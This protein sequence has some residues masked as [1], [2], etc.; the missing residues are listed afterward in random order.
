MPPSPHVV[1]VMSELHTASS[2]PL[3]EPAIDQIGRIRRAGVDDV[4]GTVNIH[5][6]IWVM[7][8]ATTFSDAFSPPAP[9]Q[10][11][12]AATRGS[13]PRRGDDRRSPP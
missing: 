12:S 1:Y 6:P 8:V 11:Q 7:S 3:I 5:R 10:R 2:R 9:V 4:V 13:R